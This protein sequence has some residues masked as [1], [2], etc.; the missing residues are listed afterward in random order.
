M[1]ELWTEGERRDKQECP[2][3]TI[4]KV[5]KTLSSF[6]N[7]ETP[8]L[9]G[10]QGY[11]LKNFNSMHKYFLEYLYRLVQGDE[12]LKWMTK[13]KTVLIQKDKGKETV[14]SDCR[15]ITCLPNVWK[16]PTALIADDLYHH[17]EA[18]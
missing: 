6:P 10:V 1:E 3:I 7:W 13:G 15:P 8:G 18:K 11:W 4:E 2:E 16:L 5:Q 17:L 12:I 9:D 14:P